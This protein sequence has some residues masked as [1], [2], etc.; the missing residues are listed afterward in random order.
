M[1]NNKAK[2][3]NF[4]EILSNEPDNILSLDVSSV[5]T[6]QIGYQAETLFLHKATDDTLTIKEYINGLTGSEYYA[7]VTA[8]R[9]KTTIRYGR[10][11]AVNPA[12]CIEIF[13]PDSYNGELLLSSQYGNIMTDADWKVERFAAET[14]EGSISLNTIT[15]P[16]IRLVSSTSLIHITKAE[17]FTDIHSVSGTI[18]ADDIEGGAKLATSSSPIQATFTSLNNIVECE[19]LNGKSKNVHKNE[20]M[21]V[22]ADGA[23]FGSE[24]DKV[25]RLIEKRENIA[26]YLPESF[27][28]LILSAGILKNSF[29]DKIL[30]DPSEYV[31]CKEYFSWERF[32]TAVLI[33]RPI[34][35]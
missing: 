22:I 9:F 24:I 27:E 2:N 13:L 23:A 11:E 30:D 31:E 21:L 17:G 5:K 3:L 6:L 14:T 34:G 35:V 33:E 29:V 26:L 4:T 12:T 28:W 20:K 15:A 32:F 1:Q 18:I 25:L 16:R 19:T 10:R 7:K 8:N